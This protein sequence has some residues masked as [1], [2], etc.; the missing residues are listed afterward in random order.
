MIDSNQRG[1]NFQPCIQCHAQIVKATRTICRTH[2]KTLP[3][4]KCSECEY[5]V[6]ARV[7]FHVWDPMWKYGCLEVPGSKY[8]FLRSSVGLVRGQARLL[9]YGSL[10]CSPTPII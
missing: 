6:S 8:L 9:F 10:S 5:V 2:D 3:L 7:G 4:S 1:Y